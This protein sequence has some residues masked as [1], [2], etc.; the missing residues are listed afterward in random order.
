MGTTFRI[1]DHLANSF[2]ELDMNPECGKWTKFKEKDV[3]KCPEVLK[4]RYLTAELTGG[5]NA[6]FGYEIIPLVNMKPEEI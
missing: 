5:P 2:D 3:L 4:G 1:G 6:I